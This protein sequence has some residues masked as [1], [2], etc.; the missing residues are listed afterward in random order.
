MTVEGF[1]GCHR[2]GKQVKIKEPVSQ[3]M[4]LDT[5]AHPADKVSLRSLFFL[6]P[7]FFTLQQK[8][9]PWAPCM[10]K[11]ACCVFAGVSSK[12]FIVVLVVLDDS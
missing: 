2:V 8:L 10:N 12:D 6:Q 1:V 4:A 7:F 3:A 5:S 9:A 11:G